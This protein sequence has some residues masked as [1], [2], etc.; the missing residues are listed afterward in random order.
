ML[1]G[2]SSAALD[3]A[4]TLA[5]NKVN[6]TGKPIERRIFPQG[7][8]GLGRSGG[9]AYAAMRRSVLKNKDPASMFA[10][11]AEQH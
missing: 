1:T 8:D 7:K 2:F 6:R 4:Q 10:I 9:V 11:V 3:D 5:E